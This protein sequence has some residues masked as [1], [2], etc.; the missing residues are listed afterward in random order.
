MC[1][2]PWMI[3][4]QMAQQATYAAQQVVS[5]TTCWKARRAAVAG[6]DGDTWDQLNE[7]FE[8]DWKVA[9]I[10]EFV[11]F[12]LSRGWTD[13]NACEWAGEIA[14]EAFIDGD[15]DPIE[16]ARKDVRECEWESANAC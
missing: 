9:Y 3:E 4:I 6:V 12:G 16:Q 8:T 11:R 13:D 15:P 5:R 14:G 1:D 2:I 7:A 10:T